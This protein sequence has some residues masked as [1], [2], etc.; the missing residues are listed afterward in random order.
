MPTTPAALAIDAGGSTTR[1]VMVNRDGECGGV[2]RS[3]RG[4]P[5]SDP[6]L[7]ASNI[8]EACLGA[9]EASKHAPQMVMAAVA[10]TVSRDFPELFNELRGHGLPDD[11]IVVSDL[12][13]A[14]FSATSAMDGSVLIVGTGAVAASIVDGK[15]AS[16]RDGLGWLL[17]DDGSGFWMGHRVARA[18]AAQLDGRGPATSLTP[19]LLEQLADIPRSTG[20]RGDELTALLTWSQSRTPV[21]LSTLA[22]L[23]AEEAASDPVA[24]AI[25][26]QAANHALATLS[27]LE[28][29]RPHAHNTYPVVLG[30]GVLD[31]GG[32]VGSRVHAALQRR[33]LGVADG[34]AGAALLAVRALGGTADDSMLA[35]ICQQLHQP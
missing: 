32:P 11:I 22:V 18:V 31:P 24:S 17:G 16:I 26:D 7:A 9:M 15:L 14:Y 34:V 6:V 20:V 2:A 5:V 27:S 21:E 12:L 10:G 19:R 23:A 4:N 29:E 35:H 3:G 8:A 30:G 25:C 1:A 28:T 13:A 33:A